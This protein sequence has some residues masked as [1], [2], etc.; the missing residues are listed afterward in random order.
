MLRAGGHNL[1]VCT[2][3]SRKGYV[4]VNL[5]KD[6]LKESCEEKVRTMSL[7]L[8]EILMGKYSVSICKSVEIKKSLRKKNGFTNDIAEGKGAERTKMCGK[9][10]ESNAPK[11][12]KKV[13]AKMQ[14]DKDVFWTIQIHILPVE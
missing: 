14:K 11:A 8:W 4:F 10:T 6:F 2:S 5:R 9:K 7:K 12:M 1:G 3:E 13:S